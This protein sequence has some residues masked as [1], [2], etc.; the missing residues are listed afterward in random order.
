[1]LD[2]EREAWAEGHRRVAG[3]D[4][5]GRGPLAGPVVAAA[6]IFDPDIVLQE[7]DGA[8]AGLTDS[9]QL[10]PRRREHFF[11]VL[12]Q[13][14]G[15]WIGIGHAEVEEI[16]RLNILRA[17]HLAMSRALTALNPPADF[18]LVDGRPVSGLSCASLALI[19]GDRRSLSIAAASI[20]AKVTRD[21]WM[22][23]LDG[24]HPEYGFA[25]HQGYGTAEHLQ[26]LRRHGPCCWHRRSFRPV[27]ACLAVVPGVS[28]A[29]RSNLHS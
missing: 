18:A 20:V 1:M 16:D 4:E 6:V 10:T 28:A 25:R 29:R 27:A 24:E 22:K 15:V 13:L 14:A 21:R 23:R 19:S 17:T 2:H 26:A 12:R 8:L 5:A 11:G 3:I 9:K 7:V